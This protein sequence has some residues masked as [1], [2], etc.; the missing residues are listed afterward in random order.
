MISCMI[1]NLHSDTLYSACQPLISPSEKAIS[2]ILKAKFV[3]LRIIPAGRNC[4][5]MSGNKV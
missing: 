3:G 5:A 2:E 4:L 1:F